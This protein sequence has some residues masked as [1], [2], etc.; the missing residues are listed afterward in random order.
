MK[1]IFSLYGSTGFIG[2]NF[3]KMHNCKNIPRDQKTPE[4]KNIIYMISTTHNYHV[5]E[6]PCI[7]V[8]TNL[9]NLVKTL[10]ACRASGIDCFNFI[11]SWFVYGNTSLPANEKSVCDPRGFYSITKHCAENLV[12]SYCRTF[13]IDY[14]ILRLCNVYG[15]FDKG[16]SKKKNALQYLIQKMKLGEDISLYNNG[17]FYRN[18]MHV[19]DVC[20]AI[21]LVCE[22]GETNEIYN[23]ASV[24][25]YMFKDIIKIASDEIGYTGNAKNIEPPEFHK[26]VQVK[27]M[28]MSSNKLK[29]L[30]FKEEISLEEGVKD[31]CK[32]Y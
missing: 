8:E 1:K 28:I 17:E 2:S 25:N 3:S 21:G 18:Y 6:D 30:G 31:L 14:R 11:S 26:I 5:L 10:D 16:S 9:L 7:D 32:K 29:D 15:N 20:R 19:E 23:I 24:N 12:A 4:T 13:N 22:S 27:D